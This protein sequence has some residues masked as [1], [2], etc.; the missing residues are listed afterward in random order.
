MLD[1]SLESLAIWIWSEGILR[2]SPLPRRHADFIAR[3]K[4]L[5]MIFPSLD[6]SLY[7]LLNLFA[8]SALAEVAKALWPR[9]A[10]RT[11]FV[12]CAAE[13]SLYSSVSLRMYFALFV[14]EYMRCMVYSILSI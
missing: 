13:L 5:Y 12:S 8:F 6:K 3:S 7:I 14:V 11:A 2:S 10:R 9:P 4:S 1:R